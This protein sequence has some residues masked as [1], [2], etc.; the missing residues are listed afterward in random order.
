MKISETEITPDQAVEILDTY[1]KLPQEFY[2]DVLG[3]EPWELQNQILDAVFRYP[4]VAVKSCHGTG[5]SWNA[6]R[7]ALTFLLT[8]PGCIVITTAPTARQVTDV[9]WRELRTAHANSKYELGGH[10]TKTGLE[11]APDWYAIGLSTTEPDRFQ[12]YHADDVLVIADE[13]AGIEEPI[14]EGIR[15][16]TSN[17]N[18][19]VLLIGNPTTL[20]GTFYE[21]FNGAQAKMVKQFTIS[22]FDTPNFIVNNINNL[23]DLL[24]FFEPPEGADE[25]EHFAKVREDLVLPYPALIS[26]AWVYQRYLE[27]GTETPMWAA[28]VMGE[29]PSQAE[30]TLIPLNMIEACMDADY[31]QEH[32]WE[33]EQDGPPEYGVDVARFGSDRTVIIER[34]GGYV[35]EPVI[36]SKK[37]TDETSHF[38]VST[39]NPETWYSK[40]KIDDTGVGGGVTDILNRLRNENPEW[41]YTVIPINFGSEPSNKEKF[42][43][44]RSEMFWNLRDL[45]IQKKIALPK[46]TLLANEL[47][48]IRY[49]YTG[50]SQIKIEAKDEIKKRLGKSPDIADALALAFAKTATSF[51]SLNKDNQDGAGEYKSN[52]SPITSGLLN[53]RF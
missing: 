30:N 51:R 14:Y 53:K 47:A 49:E 21:S 5:K 39:I 22:A 9:L 52:V 3:A 6:A 8:H 1:R 27:W 46:N 17:Q 25:L 43:N 15:A 40:L 42:F 7:I 32:G 28:R 23:E 11:F 35:H 37:S 4:E 38:L 18:A 29:F 20:E 26:P 16:I 10:I 50:K 19:H 2:K 12:G 36:F 45:I 13:A 31:R 41:R 33:V 34:H 24:A 48:S 44:K